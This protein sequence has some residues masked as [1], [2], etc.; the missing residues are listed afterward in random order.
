MSQKKEKV[1]GSNSTNKLNLGERDQNRK[2]SNSAFKSM[3]E[4][5]WDFVGIKRETGRYTTR[6]V[7]VKF[8]DYTYTDRVTGEQRTTKVATEY[9]KIVEDIVYHWRKGNQYMVHVQSFCPIPSECD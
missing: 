5:G 2:W 6:N 8:K 9:K 4:A 1:D 7:G 3:E